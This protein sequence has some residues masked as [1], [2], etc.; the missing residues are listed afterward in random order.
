[1]QEFLVFAEYTIGIGS[2]NDKIDKSTGIV[3]CVQFFL[4][5]ML[6][7]TILDV[8]LREIAP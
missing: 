1:M 5:K 7:L 6:Y 3:A 8:I 4:L 2:V